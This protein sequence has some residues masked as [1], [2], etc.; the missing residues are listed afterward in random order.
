MDKDKQQLFNKLDFSKRWESLN[1][2]EKADFCSI[3]GLPF[4]NKE[5]EP[6]VIEQWNK[7]RNEIIKAILNQ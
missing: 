4:L 6:K 1:I 3:L 7:T 2:H 5:V